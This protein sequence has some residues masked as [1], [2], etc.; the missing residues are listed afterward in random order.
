MIN[1]IVPSNYWTETS[2]GSNSRRNN[3]H[4]YPL[5]QESSVSHNI[6]A[7]ER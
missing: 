1:R 3:P 7:G 4:D 5:S 6:C 2:D